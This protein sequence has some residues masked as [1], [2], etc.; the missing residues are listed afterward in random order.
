M[1]TPSKKLTKLRG[2]LGKKGY[3]NTGV[4]KK[5]I[6]DSGEFLTEALLDDINIPWIKTV[7]HENVYSSELKKNRV[8]RPD[9]ICRIDECNFFLDS[10]N[11]SS[12]GKNDN[13]ISFSIRKNELLRL[14]NAEDFFKIEVVIVVWNRTD[15]EFTYAFAEFNTFSREKTINGCSCLE[16]DFNKDEFYV[17]KL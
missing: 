5:I 15:T 12:S 16:G 3:T 6:G 1:G 4:G 13:L 7:Q 11:L 10:K 17:L 9:Y 14:K 8:A 2:L